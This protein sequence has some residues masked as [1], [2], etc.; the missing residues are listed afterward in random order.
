M[1]YLVDDKD[2]RNEYGMVAK[3]RTTRGAPDGMEIEWQ[4]L[5]SR[6]KTDMRIKIERGEV[7]YYIVS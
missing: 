5:D 6:E 1:T 4:G 2:G 3:E 7:F